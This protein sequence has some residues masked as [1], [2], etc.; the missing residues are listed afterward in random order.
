MIDCIFFFQAEDGIRDYKV[1][2]VQTCALPIN[3]RCTHRPAPCAPRAVRRHLAGHAGRLA[4][5]P[6]VDTA[7]GLCVLDGL[8]SAR[9]LGTLRPGSALDAGE[10]PPCLA[11][12]AL[13]ALFPEQDRK[14]VV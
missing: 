5:G 11:G 14:S 4:A 6:A 13:C 8:P 3:E 2:G 12:R 9:I 7:A 1:T 10:L